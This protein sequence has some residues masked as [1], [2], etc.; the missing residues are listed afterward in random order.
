MKQEKL[1]TPLTYYGGKQ[2]L[3]SVE[4]KMPKAVSKGKTKLRC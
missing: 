1:R 4:I 2:R 3:A